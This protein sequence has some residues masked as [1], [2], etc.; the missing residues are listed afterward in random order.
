[1]AANPSGLQVLVE[2]FRSR[3]WRVRAA[4]AESLCRLG[5][6]A[7]EELARQLDTSDEPARGL[8]AMGELAAPVLVQHALEARHLAHAWRAGNVL[9]SIGEP[10]LPALIDRLRT[11]PASPHGDVLV[12]AL[13]LIAVQI[14]V[15]AQAQALPALG[16]ALEHGT[17]RMRLAALGA[18]EKSDGAAALLLP[19][20][21]SALAAAAS[22]PHLPEAEPVRTRVMAIL[23]RLGTPSIRHL[24]DALRSS[25]A[26]S[27][28]EEAVL[29]E[30]L[31]AIEKGTAPSLV[32]GATPS[33]AAA[34]LPV[35]EEAAAD[36]PAALAAPLVQRG[37][38]VPQRAT[39]APQIE[40]VEPAP[41]EDASVE[42]EEQEPEEDGAAILEEPQPG[43]RRMRKRE[44]LVL[45][46][47]AVAVVYVFLDR[48][49]ALLVGLVPSP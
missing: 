34:V 12:H 3:D 6:P 33:T 28:E 2:A 37:A 47:I 36:E 19:A 48:I 1:M 11:L 24:C 5:R 23:G 38:P 32:I 7:A 41:D 13:G 15:R 39:R 17:N 44:W 14:G 43:E 45:A 29:L 42:L 31:A 22:E 21:V 25:K 27:T 10:A 40:A 46:G 26:R 8:V 4:A 49:F 16:R 30:A 20:L 18:L 35:V 9:V